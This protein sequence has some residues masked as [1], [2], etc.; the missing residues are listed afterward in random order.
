MKSSFLID[1]SKGTS[2]LP[3]IFANRSALVLHDLLS[4]PSLEF[5]VRE[6]ARV[7]G[8]SHGLVQRVTDQLVRTGI[9]QTEGLRTAKRYRVS[10]PGQL[11]RRW[12]A[13]Y[14]ISEKCRFFTYSS[15]YA[16]AEIEARLKQRKKQK[17]C[18][19]VLALHSA[20]RSYRCSFT[21][22][23]SVEIYCREAKDREE[24]ERLLRL[25]P[26]ER[27]YEVLL[28][29]PYYSSIVQKKSERAD[30]VCV[31]SPLLTLL[32]LYH[33]PVRGEEQAEHLLRRHPA[34]AHLAA[35]LEDQADGRANAR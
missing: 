17:D 13:S 25:E 28:I 20:A 14:N 29:V 18:G 31:S 35:A 3:N 16:V 26:R 19:A 34:L 6:L 30:G 1:R 9:V 8:L 7:L 15:G 22:L 4:Q 27:G 33:F 12:F 5:G 32:D 23:Q 2:P 24:L 11:L 21:N 10:K